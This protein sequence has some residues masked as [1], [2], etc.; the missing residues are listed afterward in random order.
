[1]VK[2]YINMTAIKFGTDGWRAIIAEDYTVANVKRVAVATALWIK[3]NGGNQ[4][5]VGHDCRFAGVLF[6]QATAQVMGAHEIKVYL[7]KGF[8][9]TPMVSLGVVKKRADMGIVITASHNPASYNGFKLKSS[10]G[11]SA[12]PQDVATIET[13]IPNEVV[14]MALPSL[15]DMEAKGLLEYIDLETMYVKT[16]EKNFDLEKINT[17][18]LCCAYDAMYGAGQNA[19]KRILKNIVPLHC[20]E[21]PSFK[22]RAPEPIHRNLGELSALIKADPRI[23]CGLANDGDADRIGMYD[24]DGEFVDSHKILLLLVHY[25]FKYKGKKGKV[26]VTFSVTDKIKKLCERYGLECQITKIGFKYI[27]EIMA[28]EQVLVG[29]EESGGIATAGHIPERDG[30]WTG[31]LLMEFMAITGQS[32]KELIQEV[33]DLVGEFAFDRDDL[34][35]TDDIKQA[36]IDNCKND[37]YTS[38]GEYKVQ[39]VETMDGFK[40]H[41][42]DSEWVMI[43]PS[44]TELV[45]RVYAQA[46]TTTDVRKILD[47]TRNTLQ[48]V[49]IQKC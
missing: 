49:E 13:L 25:L 22:G 31:L 11:G 27:A 41:L 9:S 47:A 8:V 38:F 28:K 45:L 17:S 46:A 23:N 18:D 3:K 33:Y 6:A 7:A 4:V 39:S 37:V 30:I 36:I 24:E 2:I 48:A 20:D 16:V 1:M 44:G 15:A 14:T 10:Y 35:I 5:V 26:I 34:H 21:N 40:F 12:I 42:S 19:V 29:G 43:R 32:I